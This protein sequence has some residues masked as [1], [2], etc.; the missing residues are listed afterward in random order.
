MKTK[1]ISLFITPVLFLSES[2]S[3]IC[4]RAV[5]MF[6]AAPGGYAING[7][8]L[9]QDNNGMLMLYLDSAFATTA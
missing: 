4:N 1:I 9:L 8:A 6:N 3:Q 5:N 7:T 2:Q